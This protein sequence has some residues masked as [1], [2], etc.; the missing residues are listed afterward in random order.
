MPITVGI[1]GAGSLLGQGLIKSVRMSKLDC[2]LVGLD[3]FPQAVGLYW[4][5]MSYL[6]VDVLDPKVEEKQYIEQLIRILKQE[7]IQ[8]LLIGID[9]EV[10]RL[11][12]YRE[13][14]EANTTCRVIVS[15]SHTAEIGHD[16]WKTH[17]FLK[18]HGL[19]TPF[20]TIDLNTIDAF[21]EKV[22]FPL[23]VKPRCGSTSKG[24]SF[25]QVK[26]GLKEA[27]RAAGPDPLVQEAVGTPE[28]EYTCGAVVLDDECLGTIVMRR[29]LRDGNTY[30]A[31][32]EPPTGL[33]SI[34][35]E[36]ALLLKPFGPVNF[37][38]RVGKEGPKIFEINTRF[39]GT[40]VIRSL[41]G[42]NEVEAVIRWILFGEKTPL[43]P[44]KFGVILRYW[45]EFF[46]PWEV[47]REM[48]Q[49]TV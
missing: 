3:F 38:L 12:R 47:Y 19:P 30:R 31:Y 2:R 26:E 40:T 10:I 43:S 42:F 22:G 23:V 29:E 33:E 14:I 36:A 49:K 25:V 34:I 9:P 41:S 27:L 5:D 48:S 24:V 45:E 7:E 37:Q 13:Y 1:L 8:V 16:K 21:V 18:Q 4:T 35:Q 11:A 28:S 32:L 15:A 20:S 39:S 44:K 17:L 46:V 6:L